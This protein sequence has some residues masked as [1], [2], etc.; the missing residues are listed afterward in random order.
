MLIYPLV[1]ALLVR[2]GVSPLTEWLAR[3]YEFDLTP[4]YPLLM[5]FVL[6]MPSMLAGMVIGFLL[7]DQRDD[8]TLAALQVSPLSLKGYFVY[9]NTLP[10]VLSFVV[11]VIVFAVAGLVSVGFLGVIGTAASSAPLAP[12]YALAL[13]A[14]AS[15]KVQG[16]AFSKAFGVL[17]FPPVF[18][19]FF[20]PP[21]QFIFGL[22]PLYWPA[23]FFWSIHAGEQMAW[24]Y[25][26]IGF[27]YQVLLI[28]VLLR[29]LYR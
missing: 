12:I 6:L 15:N 25:L 7:L 5:S 1:I 28:H 17:L 2:L 9:R 11:T 3:R 10:L 4:Y 18:A 8:Q 23:R 24:L 26:L 16:F 21:I 22:D 27:G 29:R 19:Y 20:E 13:A 14:L